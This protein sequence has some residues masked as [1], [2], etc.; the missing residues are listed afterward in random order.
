LKVHLI[1]HPNFSFNYRNT[2]QPLDIGTGPTR[3]GKRGTS[4]LGPVGTVLWE[5]QNTHAKFLCNQDQN[6]SCKPVACIAI[7]L[8]VNH[9][10]VAVVSVYRLL[11][12]RVIQVSTRAPETRDP[13]SFFVPSGKNYLS[14]PA[15]E[16]I[17]L[18]AP[19]YDS[20]RYECSTKF[21]RN[22]ML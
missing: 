10:K 19:K 14:G 22:P 8:S 15:S 12:K 1:V 5:D 20:C 7:N 9:S 16:R 2:T 6:Y 4:Y 11:Y 13:V 3:G 18:K 17:T 21:L